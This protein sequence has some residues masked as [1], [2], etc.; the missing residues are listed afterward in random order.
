[1]SKVLSLSV[2]GNKIFLILKKTVVYMEF[3]FVKEE[4]SSGNATS[5]II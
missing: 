2:K 1:M 4:T 5:Q 3:L